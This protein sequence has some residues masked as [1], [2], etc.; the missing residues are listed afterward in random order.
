MHALHDGI[1][2]KLLQ[3]AAILILIQES[4]SYTVRLTREALHGSGWFLLSMLPRCT[5]G[6]DNPLSYLL[7]AA[8][9][10]YRESQGE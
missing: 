8:W 3:N 9:K 10:S 7:P 2:A 4:K 1:L 6:A 5:P